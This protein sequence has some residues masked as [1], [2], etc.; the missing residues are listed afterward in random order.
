[1]YLRAIREKPS[2]GIIYGIRSEP[3]LEEARTELSE[4]I[5]RVASLLLKDKY[6]PLLGVFSEPAINGFLRSFEFNISRTKGD[7]SLVLEELF[8]RIISKNLRK[9][10]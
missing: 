10:N 9:G 2:L 5:S 1:M 6:G 8:D 4:A 7:L 3:T